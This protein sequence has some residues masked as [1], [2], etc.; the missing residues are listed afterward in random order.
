MTGAK[1]KG[2][3]WSAGGVM[4]LA[5]LVFSAPG[6]SAYY[7][8]P[9]NLYYIGIALSIFLFHLFI[10]LNF[11][12]Y[13]VTFLLLALSVNKLLDEIIFDPTKLQL[14]ELLFTFAIVIFGLYRQRL[15]SR[16]TKDSADGGLCDGK[17]SLKGD[18][19][20]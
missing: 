9:A 19:H 11:R 6:F 14:N 15:I 2:L 12:K 13:F 17:R 5:D 7:G 20:E 16:S 1:Y 8:F 10:F 4:L 18:S 3:L